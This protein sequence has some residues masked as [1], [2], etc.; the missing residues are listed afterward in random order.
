MKIT[1]CIGSSCH[2][3]GSQKIAERLQ[4][5]IDDTNSSDKI[6]LC[7]T[8]CIENC[9]N[10]VSVTLD[11]KLYSLTAETTDDFFKSE[12]LKSM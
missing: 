2:I 12:V 9:Q 10:G 4:Q 7:G 1:V 11:D 3:K 8:F 5:L 6:E